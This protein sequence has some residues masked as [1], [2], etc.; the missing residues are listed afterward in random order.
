MKTVR[1]YGFCRD[2][3]SYGQVTTGF[4]EALVCMGYVDAAT[5]D[6]VGLDQDQTFEE[7]ARGIPLADVGIFTGPPM[8]A[9]R[10]A[11]AASHKVRLVMVAPN[12]SKLPERTMHTVNTFATHLLTPSA[13]G[14]TVVTRY[15]EHPVIVAP[16]GVASGFGSFTSAGVF[17]AYAD[18]EFRVLHLSSSD[19]ERKGTL[20]LV[21]AFHEALRTGAI[22]PRS[23]LT[24]VLT[25][26]GVG[27]IM[28][29][30][31]LSRSIILKTRSVAGCPPAQMSMMYGAAHL[32]CQPSRGE[33][34]GMVPLEALAAGVPIAATACTGH[35]EWF[36]GLR[37]AIEIESG[38][39][40]PIDDLPGAVAPSVSPQA[41]VRALGEAYRDWIALKDDAMQN[42]Q[43]V[44]SER[45]WGRMLAPLAEE[46]GLGADGKESP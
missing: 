42:A 19:G 13:W 6:V 11:Q 24:L 1:L 44:R 31:E 38:P 3:G 16:H 43:R 26:S 22:P 4:Y 5:L 37:G 14:K 12:S 18:Q 25:P 46:F 23:E 33:G 21:K 29:E 7:E 41:I 20:E 10:M 9:G 39:E 45:S 36:H 28:D 15:T 34:F 40:A 30:A 8:L 27:R 2:R 17:R 32:V 35:S